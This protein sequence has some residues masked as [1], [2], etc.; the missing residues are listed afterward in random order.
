MEL[1][2]RDD[3]QGVSSEQSPVSSALAKVASPTRRIFWQASYPVRKFLSRVIRSKV[4][5]GFRSFASQTKIEAE[6]KAVRK[7]E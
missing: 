1:S 4:I 5:A 2:L 6:Q 3:N 7:T